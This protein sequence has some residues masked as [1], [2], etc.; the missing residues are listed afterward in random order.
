MMGMHEAN[1]I[2]TKMKLDCRK[3]FADHAVV[4]NE[5]TKLMTIISEA[6]EELRRV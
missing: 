2:A 4:K 6:I 5:M 1:E 3:E